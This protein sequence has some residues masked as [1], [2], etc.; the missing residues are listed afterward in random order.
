LPKPISARERLGPDEQFTGSKR[1]ERKEDYVS[2]G[3][4]VVALGKDPWRKNKAPGRDPDAQGCSAN[5]GRLSGPAIS[6]ASA[7]SK[8]DRD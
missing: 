1:T 5:T 2:E 7:G 8:K 3:V 4:K 6:L